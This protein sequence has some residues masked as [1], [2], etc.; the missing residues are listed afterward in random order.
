[1]GIVERQSESQVVCGI[2]VYV[3]EVGVALK[4]LIHGHTIWMYG[5]SRICGFVR[6]E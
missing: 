2:C 3:I 1:M 6:S 5:M 4:V